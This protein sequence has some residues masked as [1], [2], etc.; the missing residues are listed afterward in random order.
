MLL[1]KKNSFANFLKCEIEKF[2]FYRNSEFVYSVNRCIAG[3]FFHKRRMPKK[4][5]DS[6]SSSA[7]GSSSTSASSSGSASSQGSMTRAMAALSTR[8]PIPSRTISSSVDEVAE[9]PFEI[10][11]IVVRDKAGDYYIPQK[12]I[13]ICGDFDED[14]S[15]INSKHNYFLKK[16]K[17]TEFN[18]THE[19]YKFK[20]E[21]NY[22]LNITKVSGI[23]RNYSG[24]KLYK[25]V[26]TSKK[27][28]K[29]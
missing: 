16:L 13:Y 26:K 6:S 21:A 22:P 12:S 9:F 27:I 25:A 17:K 10:F 24:Y 15:K 11:G 4:R 23:D 5:L 7:S 3:K 28:R 1:K 8:S 19:F 29:D 2:I 20:V 18:D 14:R